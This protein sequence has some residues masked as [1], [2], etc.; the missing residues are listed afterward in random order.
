[1]ETRTA[2]GIGRQEPGLTR[3]TCRSRFCTQ[4]TNKNPG[5]S[6][7]KRM[8]LVAGTA[9]GCNRYACGLQL[10]EGGDGDGMGGR[11]SAP[12]GRLLL[13]ITVT[14]WVSWKPP[15]PFL[16][17]VT[18]FDYFC[19]TQKK[20]FIHSLRTIYIFLLRITYSGKH[21]RSFCGQPRDTWIP[22][23]DNRLSE[24]IQNPS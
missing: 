2:K 19:F 20:G 7:G 18:S 23:L 24:T 8:W 12:E 22:S 1:M 14:C 3:C 6:S 16:Y 9:W 10:S 13:R 4:I 17:H 5:R 15:T 21:L 11:E